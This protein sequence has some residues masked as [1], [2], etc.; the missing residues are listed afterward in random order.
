MAR[1]LDGHG[2]GLGYGE[3]RRPRNKRNIQHGGKTTT[4]IDLTLI[5]IFHIC[6]ESDVESTVSS[7]SASFVFEC[8]NAMKNHLAMDSC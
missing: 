7:Q 5:H 1:W 2:A 4:M 3:A 6:F 8:N